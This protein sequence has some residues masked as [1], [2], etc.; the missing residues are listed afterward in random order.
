MPYTDKRENAQGKELKRK[1]K[2]PGSS[3]I[4]ESKEENKGKKYLNDKT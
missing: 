2:I 4:R 3:T 1:N